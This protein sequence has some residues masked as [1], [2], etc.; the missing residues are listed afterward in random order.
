MLTP[1][2]VKLILEELS[3]RNKLIIALL[4]GSGLRVGEC[5]R[6]RVQDVDLDNLSLTV[7]DGKGRKDRRTILSSNLVAPLKAAID[8]GIKLQ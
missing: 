6:L 4:Y 3:G 7:H 2:E 1:Q 8:S 5:L